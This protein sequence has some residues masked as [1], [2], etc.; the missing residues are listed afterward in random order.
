MHYFSYFRALYIC[1]CVFLCPKMLCTI[2]S[3]SIIIKMTISEFFKCV[4]FLFLSKILFET[5]EAQSFTSLKTD[6]L[7]LINI[8]F[9]F[10]RCLNGTI[11]WRNFYQYFNRVPSWKCC[12]SKRHLLNSKFVSWQKYLSW[13]QQV[14]YWDQK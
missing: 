9:A 5:L 6:M 12:I 8:G 10:S 2:Y 14:N 1:E 3:H 13:M 4:W 7:L 11:P